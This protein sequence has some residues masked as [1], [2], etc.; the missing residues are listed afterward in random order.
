M[1]NGKDRKYR[2]KIRVL[3]EQLKSKKEIVGKSA[4]VQS[5][6]KVNPAATNVSQKQ[7]TLL[8]KFMQQ[9]TSL[10]EL[11]AAGYNVRDK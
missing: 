3:Q 8:W 10:Q 1:K 7:D 9:R 2:R 11:K 5:S 6:G 4:T